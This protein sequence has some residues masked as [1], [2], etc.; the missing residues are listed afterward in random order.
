MV[1]STSPLPTVESAD[2]N[3]PDTKLNLEN[4]YVTQLCNDVVYLLNMGDIMVADRTNLVERC[5]I[6][7]NLLLIKCPGNCMVIQFGISYKLT[8]LIAAGRNYTSG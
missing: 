4:G 1:I 8:S 7:Y 2:V 6:F 3:E 5:C